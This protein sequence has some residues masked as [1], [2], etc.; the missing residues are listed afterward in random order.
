MINFKEITNA[1]IW[2]V[3][4]LEPFEEQKDFVAENIQ[5]LAEAYATRNEGGN[6]LPLAV[7]N[8][9]T[10]VGFIMIG[11]GTVGN[12]KESELIKKNY[13]LWRLMIDKKY[14]GKGFGRQ[15]LDA[16]MAL[17]RTYPFGKADKVWLSYEPENVRAR[18]IYRKYG[19]VENGE[20]C[21][22]EIIAV[23][24]L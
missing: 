21:G 20:M 14:Q 12:E 18:E 16:A 10:L 22:N 23:Y 13:S 17:I 6:A 24:D 3:C 19:F 2:K 5:S 15:T 7:Y 1:S 9:E 4:T 8:D 11:K